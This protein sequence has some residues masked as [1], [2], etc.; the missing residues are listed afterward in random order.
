M[1]K[2]RRVFKGFLEPQLVRLSCRLRF[3]VVVVAVCRAVG[4]LVVG[5]LEAA[6]PVN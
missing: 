6:R 2:N 5:L 3:V 4:S 1:H